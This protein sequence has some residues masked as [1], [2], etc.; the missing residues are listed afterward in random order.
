MVGTNKILTVSYGTFSCTLE[1]FDDAF[2]TMKAIA[3]YFRDLAADDRYFGA[4]P[5]QPDAQMMARIAEREGAR[6]V[7][8]RVQGGA[9]VLSAGAA[10]R[11]T[12]APA[13]RAEPGLEARPEPEARPAPVQEARPAP[14]PAPTGADIGSKLERLRRVVRAGDASAAPKP[15][16]RPHLDAEAVYAEDEEADAVFD[17]GPARA[18]VQP[19]APFGV[20]ALVEPR[21]T[22]GAG[23]GTH[24]PAPGRDAAPRAS[25]AADV[26]EPA[27]D[28]PRE[29]EAARDETHSAPGADA[30]E[31]ATREDAAPK[32]AAP[33]NAAP[34][35]LPQPDETPASEATASM[36]HEAARLEGVAADAATDEVGGDAAP[37]DVPEAAPMAVEAPSAED[38]EGPRSIVE[39][40]ADETPAVGEDETPAVTEAED[41][42]SAPAEEPG[43]GP[44]PGAAA[45][46]MPAPNAEAAATD[47]PG[48]AP[49][50][51]EEALL[52]RLGLT[53]ETATDEARADEPEAEAA[54]GIRAE[55]TGEGEDEA[56]DEDEAHEAAAA[57]EAGE[58]T[59]APALGRGDAGRRRRPP[60]GWPSARRGPGRPGRGPRGRGR[61]RAA[62][63]PHRPRRAH[64]AWRGDARAARRLRPRAGGRGGAD[65]RA[66][67]LGGPRP[68][69][70]A[71]RP[72]RGPGDRG[73]ARRRAGR[74]RPR[75]RHARD[76]PG[77]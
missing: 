37:R 58:A 29:V 75:R 34:E 16:P 40:D 72:R 32:V 64:L 53:G 70:R 19:A 65:G 6:R 77:G 56:H 73:R 21:L 1:G 66:R 69:A 44:K 47:A 31:A 22:E 11:S 27:L 33:E 30:P 54:P 2:G 15:A 10:A 59:D 26:A 24:A 45:D 25:D 7:E 51:E 38:A 61:A 60:R 67:R 49:E 13:T 48:D 71:G 18:T 36:P 23:L 68:G 14:A 20:G 28:A 46:A 43:A 57:P 9:V 35:G 3:E 76:G 52:A 50:D 39:A 41:L 5:P 42:A 8:A 17:I 74:G 55:E 12:L 4:E 63:A 62:Q